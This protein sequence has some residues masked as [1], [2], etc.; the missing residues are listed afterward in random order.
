VNRVPRRRILAAALLALVLLAPA[1]AA[2]QGACSPT[3]PVSPAIPAQGWAEPMDRI[4]ALE[5]VDVALRD[6]LD[7][8]AVAARVRL[9]Y[10]SDLVPTARRVCVSWHA[11][12]LGS[13]LAELLRGTGVEARAVGGDHVALAP[14]PHG[15]AA[16]RRPPT[17][18]VLE[19]IVVTGSAAGAPRRPLSVAMDVVE[20]AELRRRAAGGSLAEVL[21]GS[22]PGVWAWRQSPSSLLMRYGSIRGA[23][24]F[25]SSY[26]KVYIDGIEVANPL[27][28]TRINPETIERIEV[29]RGPQ[30]AALYGSDAISGVVN[31]VTRSGGGDR[32]RVTV[33]SDAGAVQSDFAGGT[34]LSQRH[35]LTLLAG[36]GVRSATLGVSAEGMGAF[37]P[38]AWSRSIGAS[39][40][41]RLVG[42]KTITA[43]SF[44]FS[45]EEAASPESPLLLDSV[46]VPDGGTAIAPTVSDRQRATQYTAGVNVR[47]MQSERW[48]HTAIVGLDG[49]RL[50]GVGNEAVP[51]PQAADAEPRTA[52]GAADRGT[53]RLSSVAQ[54][55]SRDRAQLVLTLGAEQSVLR[56]NTPR[57]PAPLEDDDGSSGSGRYSASIRGGRSSDDDD[58]DSRGSTGWR[59]STGLI[60]QTNVAVLDAIYLVAGTRVERNS[61]FGA[62]SG[63]STLPMVGAAMVGGR[64]NLQ[65]KV[66][67]AYG[68]GIRAPRTAAR[69][70]SGHGSRDRFEDGAL[71]P[72]R[73]AGIEFG[74][75]LFVGRALTVRATRFDQTAAG[76][77]QQVITE[78]DTN[79][80][81]GG[82]ETRR[83][84]YALQNVGKIA[85]SGWELEGATTLSRLT[86]TGALSLVDSRVSELARDYSGDL[87]VNERMLDVPAQ[88]ASLNGTWAGERW[89]GSLGAT[90]VADWIGYDRLALAQAVVSRQAPL[91]PTALGA[92]LRSHWMRYPGVTRVRAAATRDLGGGLTLHVTGDNLLGRQRGE[93][94]NVTV[95]PGR[96]ISLGLRATF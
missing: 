25:G 29:I 71:L 66:R 21:S 43:G 10:S 54:M 75:D 83:V 5:A 39:G 26:P 31:I 92:W 41:A 74:A 28:V 2:A 59:G 96:T 65:L 70:T 35:A 6:A 58:D 55:G 87:L 33:R 14:V 57:L 86:L 52:E 61:G 88:T 17:T 47:M 42:A 18:T 3:S 53:L 60:V 34:A 80:R 89:T 1:V 8:L 44:R 12:P 67:V 93:P 91:D 38:D 94:D 85:N 51:I 77:I 82:Y 63:V 49:Y 81:Q 79:S 9:S 30:G 46:F 90:R 73:Q 24:S 15:P 68:K 7:R 84:T 45:L 13:A 76:L 36:S 23:S 37:V 27:V 48:T 78:V 4:V 50:S 19:N 62:G 72:E 32:T 95:L 64:E 11:L 40:G 20:G 69:E 22:V 56:A 16:V